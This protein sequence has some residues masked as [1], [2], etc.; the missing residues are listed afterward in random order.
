M[1]QA[2]TSGLEDDTRQRYVGLWLRIPAPAP[3]L[4]GLC[5][6]PEVRYRIR[7]SFIYKMGLVRFAIFEVSEAWIA[8]SGAGVDH[9]RWKGW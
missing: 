4:H 8:V 5:N 3:A 7:R 2:L 9:D 6:G 1:F